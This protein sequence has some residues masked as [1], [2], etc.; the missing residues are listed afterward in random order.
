MISNFELQPI[1][2]SLD[3]DLKI[4]EYVTKKDYRYI[5]EYKLL[6]TI[7]DK[8]VLPT[9]SKMMY[10]K[11]HSFYKKRV[12]SVIITKVIN[13]DFILT[14]YID[15]ILDRINYPFEIAIDFGFFIINPI[16]NDDVNTRYVW[17]CRSCAI[18]ETKLITSDHD[19]TMFINELSKY[20]FADILTKVYWTHTQFSLFTKSGYVPKRLLTCETYITK[21]VD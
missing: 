3:P 14:K 1:I 21:F 2:Q 11:N 5:K 20:N 19:F 17:P 13:E 15:N 10:R 4:K 9:K 7:K 8:F 6:N 18:N 12:H 16:A